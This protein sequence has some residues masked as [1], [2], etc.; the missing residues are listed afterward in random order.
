[1]CCGEIALRTERKQVV[2]VDCHKI[3]YAPDICYLLNVPVMES[4]YN[5]F[6]MCKS[7]KFPYTILPLI[8]YIY[9]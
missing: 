7:S 8:V 9:R 3:Y 2:N 1:M 5:S 4:L 6:S